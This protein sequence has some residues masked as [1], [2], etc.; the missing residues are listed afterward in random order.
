M[1][2]IIEDGITEGVFDVDSPHE[3][4]IVIVTLF[5]GILLAIST[6]LDLGDWNKILDS[7]ET[8]VLRA[9]GVRSESLV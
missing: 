2:G 7:A 9:L 5:D 8:M 1:T 3:S 4:A 6:G